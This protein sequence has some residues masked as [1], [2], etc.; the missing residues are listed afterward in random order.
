MTTDRTNAPVLPFLRVVANGVAKDGKL[1]ATLIVTPLPVASGD[2]KLA[3]WPGAIVQHLRQLAAQ[4]GAPA[5]GFRLA[6]C[7]ADPCKGGIPQ[8]PYAAFS[9]APARSAAVDELWQRAIEGAGNSMPQPWTELSKDIARSMQGTKHSGDPQDLYAGSDS[10][11]GNDRFTDHGAIVAKPHDPQQT[12]V[13]KG[14]VSNA[15]AR[16]AAETEAARAQRIATKLV[17]GPYLPGDRDQDDCKSKSDDADLS[18]TGAIA[19]AAPLSDRDLKKQLTER[20]RQILFDRLKASIDATKDDRKNSAAAFKAVQDHLATGGAPSSPAPAIVAQSVLAPKNQVLGGS[21]MGDRASH[22]YGAWA[23]RSTVAPI[24]TLRSNAEACTTAD[25]LARLHGVYYSLQG[26]PILSRFF[27]FAFDI[28]FVLPANVTPGNAFW[29]GVADVKEAVWTKALY[30]E[31]GDSKHFWPA[32]RFDGSLSGGALAEEQ[33]HGVFNLG[34]GYDAE[35]GKHALR[36]GL[37]SLDVRGAVSGA[38]DALDLGTRHRT[39]GWTLLDRGRADQVARDLAVS[40]QQIAANACGDTVVLHAEE[41]TIGRRLDVA[42]AGEGTATATIKWR[43]LMNRFVEFIGLPVD[44]KRHL[45]RIV[46]DRLREGRILDES[47]FQLLARTMPLLGP[48]S[49]GDADKRNVEAV[50][51]EAIQTWDGTPLGVL[52]RKNVQSKCET[53]L[54]PVKRAYDLPRE[55]H[56]HL[57]PP[58]LRYGVGY[59]FAMRSVFLGGGSPMIEEA[60]RFHHEQKGAWTLPPG[61]GDKA[62][63]RHY[64]RHEGIDAP[65]LMLPSYLATKVHGAMGF[66]APG[67]ATIRTL[68][69][70][71]QPHQ[72]SCVVPPS[73]QTPSGPPYVPAKDRAYP[74][75]TVRIFIAPMVGFDFAS[76]HRVFDHAKNAE[77]ALRGGLLDVELDEEKPR[78]PVAIV[79]AERRQG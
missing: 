39:I 43:S 40:G 49:D 24:K 57:R 62:Q 4:E 36:Y 29:L 54:L 65:I 70:T 11:P 68:K 71:D 15:Q 14:I 28:E 35:N 79:K 74:D 41:L 63:P 38:R 37:T 2:F 23:Q 73:Q 59:V 17:S 60:A 67:Q 69:P 64:L 12:A 61:A 1:K 26:D 13:V 21:D 76:R 19:G 52:A 16:Y 33:R 47:S 56:S 30:S 44:A 8:K 22:I 18:I 58:P 45:D 46:N 75:K 53:A 3:F 34:L 78:F 9:V 6:V 5:N 32:S 51:E 55:Q 48:E 7:D 10:L 72:E 20:R 42:V 27:G 77:A 31:A 50:V 25:A 66:E